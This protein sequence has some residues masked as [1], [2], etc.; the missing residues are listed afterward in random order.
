MQE[1][2]RCSRLTDPGDQSKCP[3]GSGVINAKALPLLEVQA[4]VPQEESTITTGVGTTYSLALNDAVFQ[5]EDGWKW[6]N[7]CQGICFIGNADLGPCPNGGK[8]E[9]QQMPTP[10]FF[11]L[12]DSWQIQQKLQVI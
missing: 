8:H 7:K 12:Y 2:I 3:I 5:G 4:T 9:H 11:D 6:C 10:I 1:G